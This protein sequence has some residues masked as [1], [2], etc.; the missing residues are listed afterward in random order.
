[1][2]GG[3]CEPMNIVTVNDFGHIEGGA[4]HVALSSAIGLAARGHQVTLVC[5]VRPIMPELQSSS[6]R[7]VCTDQ[8]AIAHDPYRFRAGLQGLW[9]RKAGRAMASVLAPLTPEN[10]V[11]HLHGWTKC[12]SS[13]VVRVAVARGFKVVCTLN[14]YFTACPTGGFFDYPGNQACKLKPLSLACVASSCDRRGYLH[15]LWRVIRQIVQ[16]RYGHIP[17][18]ISHFIY[19]SP[20]SR[21]ILIPFLPAA[22]RL[23]WNS[24]VIDVKQSEPVHVEGNEAFVMVGRLTPDK[25]PD[26]LAQAASILACRAVFVGDGECREVIEN[27][28]PAAKITGWCSMSEVVDYLR[29]ARALVFP[30]RWYEAQPLVVL[31]AAALGVPAIVSDSSAARDLVID[32]KT[33]FWFRSGDYDDLSKKMAMFEDAALAKQFGAAAYERYWADPSD[34]EVHLRRLEDIYAQMMKS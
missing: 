3:G 8:Y 31:E 27:I 7:I 16:R 34:L 14:D 4:S 30:S 32:G 9:N 23:Y 25:G 13:S 15:K 12:L 26:L 6:V 22:S 5:G 17:D 1:M 24:N 28:D 33:G 2:Q 29:Q 10:T 11:V 20:F 21:S 18:D 19:V